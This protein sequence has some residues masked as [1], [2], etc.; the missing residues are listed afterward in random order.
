MKE[1][2]DFLF[3]PEG[4]HTT[5]L[6]SMVGAV[7]ALSVLATE[8]FGQ[9]GGVKNSLRNFDFPFFFPPFKRARS[10]ISIAL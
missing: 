6:S 3:P 7:L 4:E 5:E 8:I 2:A 9:I 1:D 10:A